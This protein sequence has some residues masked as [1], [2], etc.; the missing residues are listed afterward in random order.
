MTVNSTEKSNL[1]ELLVFT[2]NT[3]LLLEERRTSVLAVV[4]LIKCI[5]VM[6]ESTNDFLWSFTKII[7]LYEKY[8]FFIYGKTQ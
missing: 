8:R 1:G 5:N 3:L 7:R 2:G 4:T 6:Y